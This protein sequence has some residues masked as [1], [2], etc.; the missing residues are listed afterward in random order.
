MGEDVPLA[1]EDGGEEASGINRW[2][3]AW[4]GAGRCRRS[5]AREKPNTGAKSGVRAETGI[6]AGLKSKTGS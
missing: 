5:G 2:M 1:G 6:D 4:P 3:R